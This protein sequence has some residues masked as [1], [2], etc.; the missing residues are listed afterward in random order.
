[1][2]ALC[3]LSDG[4]IAAGLQSGRVEVHGGGGAGGTVVY[5]HPDHHAV[6]KLV[7]LPLGGLASG[8]TGGSVLRLATGATAP[9]LLAGHTS[10]IRAM[11]CLSGGA[12]ATGSRDC[13]VRV[14][15]GR[16]VRVLQGHTGD[17]CA[18]AELHRGILVSGSADGTA[19][20]WS[21]AVCVRLLRGHTGGVTALALQQGGV[22]AVASAG[23][24]VSLWV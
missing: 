23:G 15:D 24:T 9:E 14:W 3:V 11:L 8:G 4:R 10:R 17:V 5:N 16:H 20:I 22:L 6:L 13:T 2:L 12:L 21:G 19:R 18:L 1:M 7:A